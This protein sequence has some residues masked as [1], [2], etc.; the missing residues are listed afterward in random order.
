[1]PFF[2]FLTS[3]QYSDKQNRKKDRKTKKID[4]A[5]L[6]A[7]EDNVTTLKD[8]IVEKQPG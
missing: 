4:V 6:K 8:L 5:L 2:S 3:A 1:L 7:E